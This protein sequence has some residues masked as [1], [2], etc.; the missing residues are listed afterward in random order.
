M[1]GWEIMLGDKKGP[2][3]LKATCSDFRGR[4]GMSGMEMG[5]RTADED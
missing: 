2:G 1:G 5:K 3:S 4:I